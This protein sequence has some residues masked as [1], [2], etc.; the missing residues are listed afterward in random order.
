M[1]LKAHHLVS[2]EFYI[3]A[4]MSAATN[5]FYDVAS[6]ERGRLEPFYQDWTDLDYPVEGGYGRFRENDSKRLLASVIATYFVGNHIVKAGM[7][8][9]DNFMDDRTENKAGLEKNSPTPILRVPNSDYEE[10][11]MGWWADKNV[12]VQLACRQCQKYIVNVCC[13]GRNKCF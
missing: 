4:T 8:Y 1:S 9:E 2:T 7:A 13:K 10:F 12:R 3:E 11:Y 5:Y 6:T